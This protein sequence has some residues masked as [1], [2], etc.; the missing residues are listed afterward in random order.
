MRLVLDTN[1]VVSAMLWNGAPRYLLQAGRERRIA[2]FTSTPLLLELTEV[3]ERRKFARKIAAAHMPLDR[4]V[5]QYAG[6]STVVRPLHVAGIA[7]DPDDDVVLGTALAA[8]ADFV[9]TG[10]HGLL[11]VTCHQHVRLVDVRSALD[12]MSRIPHEK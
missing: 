5:E 9:V 8:R 2:L 4:I 1:V 11:S 3:L 12:A 6:L 10:D 7:P